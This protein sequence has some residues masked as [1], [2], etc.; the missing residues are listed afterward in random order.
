MRQEHKEKSQIAKADIPGSLKLQ[1]K[2]LCA[3]KGL[4]MSVISEHLLRD[5]LLTGEPRINKT[6]PF[7]EQDLEVISVYV[8][9]SL[10][11]QL[12]VKCMQEKVTMKFVLFQLIQ[13]WVEENSV[14]FIN[15]VTVLSANR[16]S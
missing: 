7:P 14:N 12:K 11:V 2:I 10:K 1:F 8:P 5:W 6:V 3:R 15:Q 16:T 9:E 13:I 4:N